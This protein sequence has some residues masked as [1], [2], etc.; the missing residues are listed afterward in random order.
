MFANQTRS[1]RPNVA[2]QYGGQL[3]AFALVTALLLLAAQVRG[4]N[5]SPPH[6]SQLHL[7]PDPAPTPVPTGSRLNPSTT[8]S[9][10]AGWSLDRDFLTRANQA[11][12]SRDPNIAEAIVVSPTQFSSMEGSGRSLPNH[13]G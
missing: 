6:R 10:L 13:L 12:V 4:H 5:S 3:P 8:N 1:D 2:R 9:S 7:R 11:G